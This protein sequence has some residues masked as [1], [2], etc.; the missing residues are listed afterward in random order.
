MRMGTLVAADSGEPLARVARCEGPIER[1]RGL[2]GRPALGP[3]EGLLIA[4]CNSIHTVGMRY[5]IDVVFLD[6]E[7]RI[8][9]VRHGLAPLRLAAAR[10]ARSVVELAS[11]EARRLGLLPR[12]C[13]R[14]AVQGDTA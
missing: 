4:P 9:A 14:W 7:V 2:L 8:V 6:A 10:G 11:G 5:A 1:M 12:R 3:A 13:V